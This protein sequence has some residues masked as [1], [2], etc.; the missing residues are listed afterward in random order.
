MKG[1]NTGKSIAEI[2]EANKGGYFEK[3][4]FII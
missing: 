3:I 1:R 4:W 2:I